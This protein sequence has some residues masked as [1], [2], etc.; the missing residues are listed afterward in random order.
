LN[1]AIRTEDPYH[2]VMSIGG[3]TGSPGYP[4]WYFSR[5]Y[6]APIYRET[7]YPFYPCW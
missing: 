3:S 1:A 6:W 4:R 7:I 2:S 5:K